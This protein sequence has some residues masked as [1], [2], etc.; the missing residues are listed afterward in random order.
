MT[1]ITEARVTAGRNDHHRDLFRALED[2]ALAR[3][4]I[5]IDTRKLHAGFRDF[6]HQ[7]SIKQIAIEWL[8]SQGITPDAWPVREAYQVSLEGR[9]NQRGLGTD[10]FL[11]IC[12]NIGSKSLTLGFEN[13]PAIYRTIARISTLNDFRQ[14]TRAGLAAMEVLQKPGENGVVRS[15]L[16]SSV[17]AYIQGERYCGTYNISYEALLADEL[18]ALT[19]PFYEGGFVAAATVDAALIDLLTSNAGVGPTL[20]Q[21]GVALFHSTH[22]NYTATA[23]APSVSTLNVARQAMRRHKDPGT[24]RCLNIQPKYMLVPPSLEGEARILCAS[25]AIPGRDDN[26]ECVVSPQLEDGTDGTTAWYLLADPRIHDTLD[27]GFVGGEAP[28]L[29]SQKGWEVDGTATRIGIGFGVAAL[30]H[31]GMYRKKGA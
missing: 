2:A 16:A 15:A 13:A 30:D 12:E 24:T 11:G 9:K 27:V 18:D 1:R 3:G 17:R 31:R 14:T 5:P 22:A 6:E 23:G 25:E 4:G 29:V 10:D 20:T 7:V 26:L 21:D 19:R 28:E 8:R